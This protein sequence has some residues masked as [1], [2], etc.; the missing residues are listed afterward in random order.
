MNIKSYAAITHQGPLLEVNEDAYDFDFKK[1]FYFVLDGFGGSGIGDKAVLG[2]KLQLKEFL[3]K[4]SSDPNATMPFYYDPQ[5]LLEGNALINTILNSHHRLY[6]ENLDRKLSHRAGYSGCFALK[7]ESC[8]VLCGIG[9]AQAFLF[10]QGHL[11]RI[12]GDQSLKLHS[13]SALPHNELNVPLSG[14]GLYQNVHFQMREVKIQPGDLILLATDGLYS[15][16]S[17][18]ELIYHL[19]QP[20]HDHFIRL[21]HM[22]NLSNSHGNYDNQTGMIIEF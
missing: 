7:S 2:A 21:S 9:T 13:S 10:R 20:H 12:F 16:L 14:V 22:I 3:F 1:H 8:W 19:S 15:A 11:E 17:E 18:N 5:N 4:L 6:K